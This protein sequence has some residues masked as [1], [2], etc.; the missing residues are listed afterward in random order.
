MMS[1]SSLLAD[2][3]Q[4][5]PTKHAQ[6]I[7]LG[8]SMKRLWQTLFVAFLRHNRDKHC[9]RPSYET[10]MT[11]LL[12]VSSTNRSRQTLFMNFLQ[13]TRDKH[14]SMQSYE[15]VMTDLLLGSPTKHAWQTLFKA[16]LQN[17]HDR[18]WSRQFYKIQHSSRQSKTLST[19]IVQGSP[20]KHN[21]HLS[22]QSKKTIQFKAVWNVTDIAQGSPMKHDTVQDSLMK[23]NRHWSRQSYKTWH[24]SRRSETWQTL[25]MAVLQTTQFKAVLRN[26]TDIV[27]GSNMK[28]DRH[29]S[30]QSYKTRHS[31]RQFYETR[32][33]LFMAVIQNTPDRH[34]SRQSDKTLSTDIVERQCSPRNTHITGLN[35]YDD[36]KRFIPKCW[37]SVTY[38]KHPSSES[39]WIYFIWSIDKLV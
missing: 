4:G 3:F 16:V 29:C 23:H 38:K 26:T 32:Q 13:N 9:T 35:E 21:R 22:I 27:Q 20:T 33:I 15:T 12:L 28:H 7:V 24:S 19:D 36:V 5:S 31:S 25:F 17:T 37:F 10:I 30:R 1:I 6:N 11:D 34:C 14:C 2:I 39:H 8:S 18:H